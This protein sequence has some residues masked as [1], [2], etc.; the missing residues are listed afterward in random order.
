MYPVIEI[1]LKVF[2]LEKKSKK[3]VTTRQYRKVTK[4]MGL[5][6]YF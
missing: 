4:C 5:S 1:F 3:S 2:S 6:N